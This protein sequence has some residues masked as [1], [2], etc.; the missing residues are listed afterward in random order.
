MLTPVLHGLIIV[1]LACDRSTVMPG[2]GRESCTVRF[3]AGDNQW[4][5]G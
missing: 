1:P 2:L 3:D 4:G 5:K